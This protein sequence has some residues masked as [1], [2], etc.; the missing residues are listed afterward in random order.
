MR[1]AGFIDLHTHTL[2]SDGELLPSELISRAR[3]AGYAAIGITDHADRS[4]LEAVIAAAREA[5]AAFAPRTGI[6]A[7]P[8]VELTYVPPTQ[9]AALVRRARDLGAVLIVVHG[10]TTVEPVPAGTNTA[11]LRAEI[12]ILAHPGLLTPAEARLA[13]RRGI[14]LELTTRRGHSLTNGHVARL[15]RA[16]GAP[17]ILNTDT[18]SPGDLLTPHRYAAALLGA[19]LTPAQARLVHGH[20][21]RLLRTLVRRLR[22][23]AR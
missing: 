12:D 15:A 23:G 1:S 9:L 7:L 8:G 19:G 5:C 10:E 17:L 4:N 6:V 3:Q 11:A 20:S 16:A 14:A 21:S 13:A 2:A 22:A 18:H